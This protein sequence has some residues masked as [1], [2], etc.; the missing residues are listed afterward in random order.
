MSRSGYSEDCDD[1]YVWLYMG[2]V[3]RAIKG[4]RGQK[5]LRDFIAALDA[6]PKKELI[7][8]SF[9]R[10]CGVCSLGAL[11]GD[12]GIDMSDLE[13]RSHPDEPTEYVDEVDAKAV[14][15]R[16]D[17]APSMVREVMWAKDEAWY[18]RAETPADRWSRMRRWAESKLR[19]EGA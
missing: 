12:R 1:G 2:S 15:A 19:K 6:M 18:G 9:S 8:N 11:A 5:A 14:G 3:T 16:L 10:E 17:I 13:P 4:K 7:A